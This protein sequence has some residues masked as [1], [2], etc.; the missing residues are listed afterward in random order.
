LDQVSAEVGKDKIY[1]LDIE[2]N[3]EVVEKYKI[4]SVPTVIVFKNGK[5][6]K[7]ENKILSKSEVFNLLE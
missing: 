5:E 6:I 4:R 7:R 1:K 2:N 3:D